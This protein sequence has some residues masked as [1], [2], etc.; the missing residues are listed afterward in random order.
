M[1][2]ETR[3]T[4]SKAPSL[5]DLRG[6]EY[7]FFSSRRRHTIFDCDWSSDVC[8]SDL[9][10]K[11]EEQRRRESQ[12]PKY[13][14]VPRHAGIDALTNSP[15]SWTREDRAKIVEQHR[16]RSALAVARPPTTRVESSLSN[17]SYPSTNA[18]PLVHI[19]RF[20]SYNVLAIPGPIH[21]VVHS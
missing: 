11:Q 9:N 16:R 10:A 13:R 5:V 15:A 14:H 12:T 6:L 2:R 3:Y 19:P 20:H 8:S 18:S 21:E 1:R 7:F 4:Q 17:V